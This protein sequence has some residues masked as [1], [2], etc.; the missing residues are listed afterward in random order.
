MSYWRD[1]WIVGDIEVQQIDGALAFVEQ[2][3]LFDLDILTKDEAAECDL[4]AR[5]DL[6]CSA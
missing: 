1:G 6:A 3:A 2:G 4:P 5:T